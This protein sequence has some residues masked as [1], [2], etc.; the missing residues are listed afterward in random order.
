MMVES[1]R[2]D[3]IIAYTFDKHLNGG[4]DNWPLLLPM[5]KSAV[6]AMDAV[7]EFLPVKTGLDIEDF[8]VTGGSKRGWTT[9]LTAAYDDFLENPADHRVKA[10]VPMVIDVLNIDEQ[11]V[12][13]K[14][15]Y[16]G[17]TEHMYGDYA[18][19]MKPYVE[20]DIPDKLCMHTPRGPGVARNRRS[21]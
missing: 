18:E 15:A 7:Q 14:A 3:E 11:M 16:E 9:W 6:R 17:V 2:E 19:A 8:V 12:H 1:R 10:I 5:V 13:H 21:V 20:Y 4:E